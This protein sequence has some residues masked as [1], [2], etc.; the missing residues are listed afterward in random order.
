MFTEGLSN[1]HRLSRKIFDAVV[2]HMD[3]LNAVNQARIRTKL[4]KLGVLEEEIRALISSSIDPAHQSR[5]TSDLDRSLG[6][7]GEYLLNH[8]ELEAEKFLDEKLQSLAHHKENL[9]ERQ[10][11]ISQGGLN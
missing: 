7:T 11:N 2:D 4:N 10:R 9:S 1:G 5:L 6:Y 8:P 3:G